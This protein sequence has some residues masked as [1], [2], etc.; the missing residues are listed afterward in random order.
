MSNE[1]GHHA[2]FLNDANIHRAVESAIFGGMSNAGQTCI[3]TEE[4]FVEDGIYNDF[5]EKISN[6]IKSIKSGSM[7]DYGSMIVAQ[8][9]NNFDVPNSVEGYPMFF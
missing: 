7:G 6:R 8:K 4:V 5:V 2:S 1:V 9:T 3:S